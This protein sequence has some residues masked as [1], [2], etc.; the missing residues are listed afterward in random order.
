MTDMISFVA[1]PAAASS[2]ANAGAELSGNF[3]TF[4]KILTA[5]I[6]NQDP[7]QPMD[8]AQ[9]T[10]QLV[11][12]SGVEQQIKANTSLDKLLKASNST[13]GASLSGYLGQTAEINSA[14]AE[15][16][17]AG[18]SVH[19][20]YTL[21]TDATTSTVTVQDKSGHVL[22]SET[23][24]KTAGTYDFVWDGKLLNGKTAAD[25]PYWISVVAGDANNKA[26]TPTQSVVAT[27]TGVDLSYGEPALTTT[28]GVYS[29]SDVKQLIQ[30]N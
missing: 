14:G 16:K 3:D 25:G 17:G 30:K 23:G 13:A 4:L 21:P 2:T 8:S 29:Y 20:R 26:I 9:F 27:I 18:D 1:P 10:Q 22:Y 7:L 6:Q 19:W 24:K 28:S 11:Q 12:F 15:F 5:Q